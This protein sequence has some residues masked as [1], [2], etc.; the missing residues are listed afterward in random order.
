MGNI[1]ILPPETSRRIAAGEVIDR[2]SSALREIIDNAIDADAHTISVSI[3]QGGI[4]EIT[5]ADDGWG[6]SKE[7]LLLSIAEHATSKIYG[8]DDILKA[9]T[10]GFRGE[11]LASIAAVA[12]LEIVSKL[13]GASEGWR[14]SSSPLKEPIIEPFACKEGTRLTMRG[15]F[16][17]YPARRQFLKRPQSEAFLC[18]STFIERALSHPDICFR[19]AVSG[20]M[21]VM[22][23]SSLK[24]RIIRCYTELSRFPLFEVMA[25][26]S[27][28]KMYCV[29]ADVSNYR[30]DRKFLQVF[31]NKRRV[32]EWNLLS[33]ME[34]EFGKYLPGGAHAIAFLLIEIDPSLADFNIHPA[35]KEVRLKKPAEV[36]TVLHELLSHELVHRYGSLTQAFKVA[37]YPE[38]E[39]FVFSTK[40]KT[41]GP[42]LADKSHVLASE[43]C[44]KTTQR[45]LENGSSNLYSMHRNYSQLPDDFW[46]RIRDDNL[47]ALRYIGKG[48]GPFLVFELSDALFILDQHAAH[49]RIL[50]NKIKSNKGESQM[51][52][53]PY[54]LEPYENEHY[55]EE[56]K[57]N[58]EFV[59]YR[60]TKDK[61]TWIVDAVPAIA[62][63][64]ALEALVEWLS[65][66]SSEASPIDA[67]IASL[68]CKAAIKDGD[69][70]DE[71][72]ALKLI[73]ESLELPEPRCPH[74][75]PIYLAFSREQL[76]SMFG[77]SIG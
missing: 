69:R 12:R 38:F 24:D 62:A 68:A 15:L 53:V 31:V 13:R 77:R 16:E 75:R 55:L 33:L 10:L 14:L 56:A 59:G 5:V 9:K 72:S 32:P 3:A 6:M 8:P 64:A 40:E 2:P 39:D 19:W 28:L 66:P 63:S 73:Q 23:P 36:R 47:S 54:L 50:Y 30:R 34:Y 76:Y 7:D 29:Y 37:N 49:E 60:I 61:N 41:S 20:D 1:R 18:R 26:T 11:A 22:M 74:G 65:Q 51:L 35:K 17:S 52:L 46:H 58:L 45:V 70:L 57:D 27:E 48:P 67:L 4:E 44:G 71:I 42:S 21:D 25:E 43:G